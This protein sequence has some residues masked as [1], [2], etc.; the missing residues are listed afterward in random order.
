MR[1]IT[2]LLAAVIGGSVAAQ[3]AEKGDTPVGIPYDIK[4]EVAHEGY[5]ETFCW[6]QPRA[7]AIPRMTGDGP[8]IIIITLQKHLE[9]SDFYSGLYTMRS[10]DFGKTWSEPKEQPALGWRELPDGVTLGICDFVPGWHAPTAR[11]LAV[12]HTVR[13]KNRALMESPHPRGLGY[14]VYDPKTD[15]WAPW[16][17]LDFPDKEKFWSAGAGCCQWLIKEDG[18]LLIPQYYCPP[19][20]RGKG[21]A[22]LSASTVVHCSFDGTTLTYLAHGDEIT[23]DVPRGCDEPSLILFQGRYYLTIRN[24]EKGYVTVGGDGLHFAPLKPWTFD[25][26][27]ELGSYNTQQH[28]LTHGDGLFLVYTRRGANND[29]IFRHRAPLF[30]AQVDPERLC[31]IRATERVAVPERGATLGNFGAGPI[32]E[33]ESWVTVCEGMFFPEVYKKG[34]ATG[35]LF[36]ARVLWRPAE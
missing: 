12:G 20:M 11:L 29:H 23:L 31:V 17:M 34:G 26:G 35:A 16:Q 4:L 33:D 22:A 18:T 19:E 27:G 7:A 8:P 32:T 25:D 9:S 14:A 15:Q 3:A 5:D 6:F 21:A 24:D 36:V 28:W 2:M 10:D 30:M 13:Y 1:T